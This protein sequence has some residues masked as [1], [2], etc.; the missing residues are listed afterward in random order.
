M[1][2]Q[3]QLKLVAFTFGM[4]VL[5]AQGCEPEENFPAVSINPWDTV[6]NY[7]GLIIPTDGGSI[8]FNMSYNYKGEAIVFGSKKYSNA[9]ND[10]FTI[11]ELKHYLT[12]VI[13][14]KADGETLN[15]GN[16]NLLDAKV[17]GSQTFTL[18]NIPAG[19][20]TKL[21][22]LLAVDSAKN[23]GGLQEG[24]LDPAYG[25]F[26][27]WST[28]YIF[29]RINGGTNAGQNYS[30]DL[31]GDENL[32]DVSLDLKAYKLKAVNAKLALAMDVNEMFQNPNL[33]S[34]KTDGYTIHSGIDPA[35]KKLS[36]NMKDMVTIQ[37]LVP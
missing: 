14:T 20:Y 35:G 31:G 32:P 7:Q 29:Y 37:S 28:G 33:F 19:N 13:L 30:F 16:Y 4:F 34:F 25:M 9:A 8:A 3:F 6:T 15:L 24:A 5:F 2:N 11:N 12:N 1:S 10:T 17:P 18:K 36:D 27:T 23:H 21:S 26:W 22:F